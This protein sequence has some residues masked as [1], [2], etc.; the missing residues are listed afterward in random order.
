MKPRPQT[1]WVAVYSEDGRVAIN[2]LYDDRRQCQEAIRYSAVDG[3]AKAVRMT[4]T[5]AKPAKKQK[6]KSK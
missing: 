4:M 2:R 6:G 1:A 5:P 3:Y